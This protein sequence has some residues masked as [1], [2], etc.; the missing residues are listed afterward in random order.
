MT[1]APKKAKPV[2]ARSGHAGFKWPWKETG[3]RKQSGMQGTLAA[4]DVF[5]VNSSGWASLESY[6]EDPGQ[7]LSQS[8]TH[9]HRDTCSCLYS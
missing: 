2:P 8:H 6:Q 4:S 3:P 7:L 5:M 1:Q 9:T